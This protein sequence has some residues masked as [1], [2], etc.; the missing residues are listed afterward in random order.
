M[1]IYYI[2]TFNEI[3]VSKQKGGQIQV[4][5]PTPGSAQYQEFLV[6]AEF[7]NEA[8]TELKH[9]LYFMSLKCKAVIIRG[10]C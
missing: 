8:H 10:R 2:M 3:E 1:V 5:C 6:S 7:R 4:P 9:S